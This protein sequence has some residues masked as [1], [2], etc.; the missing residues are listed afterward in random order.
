[1][2]AFIEDKWS[3]IV[4]FALLVLAVVFDVDGRSKPN[5][6]DCRA[7]AAANAQADLR[8]GLIS[9]HGVDGRTVYYFMGCMAGVN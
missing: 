9:R 5:R 7:D 4:I 8:A 3:L 1:M 2:A 6:A